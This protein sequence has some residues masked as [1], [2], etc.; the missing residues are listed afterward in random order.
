[1]DGFN[2]IYSLPV[3][4]V[5]V[6]SRTDLTT[7]PPPD[8]VVVDLLPR[9]MIDDMGVGFGLL[10]LVLLPRALTP[11]GPDDMV[12]WYCVV[13]LL[14]QYCIVGALTLLCDACGQ[15]I[16]RLVVYSHADCDLRTTPLLWQYSQLFPR[17][18]LFWYCGQTSSFIVTLIGYW[19]I[20]GAGYYYW[21]ELLFPNCWL[22]YLP[23][24]PVDSWWL[25][26][27]AVPHATHYGPT[28]R[29]LLHWLDPL[30]L[31][32]DLP[33]FPTLRIIVCWRW[34]DPRPW[35]TIPLTT[36]VAVAQALTPGQ[37]GVIPSPDEQLFWLFIVDGY[38][39]SPSDPD[40]LVAAAGPGY[41]LMTGILP[42]PLTIYW[43]Y[44]VV[45]LNS[46]LL[47]PIPIALWPSQLTPVVMT[48]TQT[49]DIYIVCCSPDW[50][51]RAIATRLVLF[52]LLPLPNPIIDWTVGHYI[53]FIV[54]RPTLTPDSSPSYSWLPTIGS[55]TYQVYLVVCYYWRRYWPNCALL[56]VIIDVVLLLFPFQPVPSGLSVPDPQLLLMCVLIFMAWFWDIILTDNPTFIYLTSFL[57]PIVVLLLL[58]QTFG[59][60]PYYCAR[61]SSHWYY[62]NIRAWLF[63]IWLLL[64]DNPI[65]GYCWT[66]WTPL[67]PLI[68]LCVIIVVLFAMP[69]YFPTPLLLLGR[70]FF[71]DPV[72]VIGGQDQLL[73]VLSQFLPVTNGH[74]NFIYSS[75]CPN[76]TWR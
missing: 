9:L 43:H 10:L 48:L 8:L 65:P 39:R 73:M 7:K 6:D 27:Q 21:D 24:F 69:N 2:S 4:V 54:P 18:E 38:Y 44:P 14:I 29:L 22:P 46:R 52:L 61:T 34:F 1:M 74:G 11:L 66:F 5:I 56:C 28:P 53:G 35:L 59:L 15:Y 47:F 45:G 41:W 63:P 17:R 71:P 32:P 67:W 64:L 31:P 62:M 72:V 23:S 26:V 57:F 68:V 75:C 50:R 42:F 16:A 55:H 13:L 51:W 36:V 33:T 3:I 40:W 70:V 25:F 76:N 49:V 30:V 19:P 58:F 20:I 12:P 37:V 60:G